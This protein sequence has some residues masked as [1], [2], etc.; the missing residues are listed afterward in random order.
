MA[1]SRNIKPAF[2]LNEELVELR[3]EVRLLFIGLWTLA[4]REGRLE[5]RPKRIKMNLFPADDIDI[6]EALSELGASGFVLRYEVE[7]VKIIQIV[8]FAKHQKPH[9]QEKDSELPPPP[10][11]EPVRTLV[12]VNPSDSLNPLTD[13]LNTDVRIADCGESEQ[14]RSETG[15][16]EKPHTQVGH[17]FPMRL[18]WRPDE[19]VLTAC[20]VSAGLDRDRVTPAILAAFTNYH[21]DTGKN[22]TLRQWVTKL[23]NWAKR[24]KSPVPDHSDP[25]EPDPFEV[26]KQQDNSRRA[27]GDKS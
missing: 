11:T 24:E 6:D 2:F 19:E 21:C 13:S 18:D 9:H 8:N 27:A 3:Y 20:C 22:F 4:D 15:Q 1:R 12:G 23:I 25:N 10:S 17:I 5:D 26:Y 16:S 7:K 14:P